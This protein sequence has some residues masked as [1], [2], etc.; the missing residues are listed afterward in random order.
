MIS[1]RKIWLVLLPY[2]LLSSIPVMGAL[3]PKPDKAQVLSAAPGLQLPFVAN[4]GQVKDPA[5]AFTADTFACRV[6][7]TR[8]GKIVY[9]RTQASKDGDAQIKISERIMGARIALEGKDR[10]ATRISYFPGRDRSQ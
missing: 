4:Q 3:S 5:V 2:L 9:V 10:R 7:V 1:L 8:D 6:E